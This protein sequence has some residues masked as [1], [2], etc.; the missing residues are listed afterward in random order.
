MGA[1]LNKCKDQDIQIGAHNEIGG[2][3]IDA[4]LPKRGL[5]KLLKVRYKVTNVY[6]NIYI[7]IY[8]YMCRNTG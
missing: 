5:G 4:V 8:I 3:I 2:Y 7:Y 1:V 6:T